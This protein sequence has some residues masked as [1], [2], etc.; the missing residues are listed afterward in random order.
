[1]DKINLNDVL[2]HGVT[3]IL[4]ASDRF[5]KSL[6]RLDLILKSN[7]ILSRSKQ[8]EV[9]TKIG[10]TPPKYNKILW[11]GEDYVSVC[12]KLSTENQSKIKNSEAFEDFINYSYGLILS[13]RI[14]D[15]LECRDYCFSSEGKQKCQDGEIQVKDAIPAKYFIG[16]FTRDLSDT[17][18]VENSQNF[19]FS[20]SDIIEIF[21]SSKSIRDL[22]NKNG[23]QNLPIYS[24]R[25]GNIITSAENVLTI[26]NKN[27]NTQ[28]SCD[29]TL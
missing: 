28:D 29:F 9:L 12:S 4:V 24:I 10:L 15:E 7:A 8:K 2:F 14:L 5:E 13:K 27:E 23:Y 22:L 3:N 21:A 26:L 25:D 18:I 16:V 17:E 6:D 11:N 1:M 19:D 20:S